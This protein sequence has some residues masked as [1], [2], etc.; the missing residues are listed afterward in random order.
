MK[1][2][3]AQ[4]VG[5]AMAST[6]QYDA[7][8]QVVGSTGTWSGPFGHAGGFGYQEDN[9]GLQL[10]GHRYYDPST[11]RFLT[12]DPIK[13]GRNWYAYGA[14]DAAPVHGVDPD[15][16]SWKDILYRLLPPKIRK[17]AK[18]GEKL[19]KHWG[20]TEIRRAY[21][22]AVQALAGLVAVWRKRGWTDEMIARELVRLRNQLK[23]EFR[24]Y[25]DDDDRE[26]L[27]ERNEEKYGNPIGPT[28]DQLRRRKTDREIIESALKT[29]GS[30]LG[31]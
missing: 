24:E 16:L 6:R 22:E 5:S 7:F 25:M 8:G 4:S 15:G 9:T 21:V 27:E 19:I 2:Q 14:G 28:Y 29:G 10:L 12:R 26:R 20:N 18:L 3:D 31:L 13:D 30:D 23:E 11:G 1:S 17:P